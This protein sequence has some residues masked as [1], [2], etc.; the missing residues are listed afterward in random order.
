MLSLRE[1]AYAT[2]GS[3]QLGVLIVVAVIA[4][5]AGSR[6]VFVLGLVGLL[7]GFVIPRPNV[8]A[9]YS[10]V[11]GAYLG[12]LNAIVDHTVLWS[13]VGAFGGVL[14]GIAIIRSPVV[15]WIRERSREYT[16]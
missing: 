8:R 5:L 10:S 7:L 4:F 15:Y 13:L 6:L 9:D 14:I 11:E 12:A 16:P 1:I 3:W 2:A